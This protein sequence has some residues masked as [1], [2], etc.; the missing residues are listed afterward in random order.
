VHLGTITAGEIETEGQQH[1]SA[2]AHINPLEL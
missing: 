1:N 2:T